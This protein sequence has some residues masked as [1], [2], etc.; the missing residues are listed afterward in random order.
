[1]P[2]LPE[3]ETIKNELIQTVK[4]KEI[5]AVEVRLPKILKIDESVSI[6]KKDLE[7]PAALFTKTLKN[8]KIKNIKRRAKLIIV[9]L[10]NDLSIIIHLKMTGRLLYNINH[11]FHTHFIFKFK[12]S[13]WLLFDDLR[14]FGY[15]KLIKSDQLRY[16]LEDKFGP[17]PLEDD[18][19]LEIFKNILAKK[20]R[21]RIKIF[22]MDQKNIA[23]IGNIYASEICFQAKVNP[24]RTINTLN[25]QETEKLFLAIKEILTLA[26]KHKGTSTDDYR[27]IFGEKG[28]FVPFLKVYGRQRKK[29]LRKG[30]GGVIERISLGNRGTFFCGKCQR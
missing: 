14:Q 7:N 21:S 28:K 17:E 27:D 3:V 24:A 19:T 18:F 20:K 26:V 5:M 11:G 25:S 9:E 6:N 15:L 30:C 2:E 8:V 23:G 12:N 29:C 16:L 13:D 4:N 10:S 1:M 22:L